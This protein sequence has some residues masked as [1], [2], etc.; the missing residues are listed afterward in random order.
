MFGSGLS[1]LRSGRPRLLADDRGAVTLDW[2]TLA[3]G[4]VILSAALVATI[5]DDVMRLAETMAAEASATEGESAAMSAMRIGRDAG[6]TGRGTAEDEPRRLYY[7][8]R[9]EMGGPLPLPPLDAPGVSVAAP[10]DAG[11]RGAFEPEIA[12]PAAQDPVAMPSLA[13]MGAMPAEDAA[14]SIAAPD[15]DADEAAAREN[16]WA[17]RAMSA[18]AGCR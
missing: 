11:G 4:G 1:G 8:D 7:P 17:G 14:P 5:G 18:E 6:A 10:S 2:L 3:A 13:G 12:E 9:P 16:A 15:C